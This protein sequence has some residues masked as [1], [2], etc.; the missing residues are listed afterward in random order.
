MDNET[1][2]K[3]LYR[4]ILTVHFSISS[5]YASLESLLEDDD[6][7]SLKTL[8]DDIDFLESS[9]NNLKSDLLLLLQKMAGETNDVSGEKTENGIKL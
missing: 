4:R 5:L 8:S 1:E 9:V 6:T 3:R 2:V 7:E